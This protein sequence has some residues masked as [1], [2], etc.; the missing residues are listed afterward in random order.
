KGGRITVDARQLLDGNVRV[1]V[2][3]DGVGMDEQT[4]EHAIDPFFTTKAPGEGTGLGLSTVHGIAAALGGEL[5][6][7]SAPGQ[8]TTVD[9]VIASVAAPA[10]SAE[11]SPAIPVGSGEQLLLVDDEPAVLDAHRRMLERCG[12]RVLPA[13]SAEGAEAL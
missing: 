11:R 4:R 8:G 5:S 13:S 2:V 7:T 9:V 1:R 3:D 10:E 6:I 12:Y